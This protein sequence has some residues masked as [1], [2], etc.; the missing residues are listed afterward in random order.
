MQS[1]QAM[2]LIVTGAL[3]TGGATA[4]AVI[5]LSP[6]RPTGRT[7]A[8]IEQRIADEPAEPP[9]HDVANGVWPSSWTHEVPDEPFTVAQAHIAMQQHR[10]CGAAVCPRK[11]AAFRVL[12]EAGHAVPDPRAE[13]YLTDTGDED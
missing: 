4:G 9:K 12:I 7:V 3:F 5:Y 1:W 6:A 13:K 2:V 8:E 11:K 10:R